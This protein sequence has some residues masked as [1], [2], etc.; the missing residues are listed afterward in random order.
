MKS[1]LFSHTRTL[2]VC[3]GYAAVLAHAQTVWK[4]KGTSIYSDTP[5]QLRL[6]NVQTFNPRNGKLSEP[7]YAKPQ[8]PVKTPAQ[9]EENNAYLDDAAAA[10]AVVS[11]SPTPAPNNTEAAEPVSPQEQ[12]RRNLCQA[13]Q[14]A[15]AR[16]AAAGNSNLN[17]QEADVVRHCIAA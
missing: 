3:L 4:V 5:P 7:V 10:S 11:V 1:A 9:T 6:H 14:D 13:A 17:I 12:N 16:A 8:L 2:A 15:L